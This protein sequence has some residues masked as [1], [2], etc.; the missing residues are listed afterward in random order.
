MF[1][2][3]PGTEPVPAGSVDELRALAQRKVQ[4]A[5]HAFEQSP[6]PAADSDR[7]VEQALDRLR[8]EL[9][10]VVTV[11]RAGRPVPAHRLAKVLLGPLAT[12][13]RDVETAEALSEALG[14]STTAEP[15]AA[16]DVPGPVGVGWPDSARTAQRAC[17]CATT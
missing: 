14:A 12:R 9:G 17:R 6:E 8:D 4:A 11:D 13:L 1:R 16:D 3:R 5:L 2:P 10:E 7:L 15:V